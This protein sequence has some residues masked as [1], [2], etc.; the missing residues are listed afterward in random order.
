M[1]N[2]SR[3]PLVAHRVFPAANAPDLHADERA[4][5]GL[6]RDQLFRRQ[7]ARLQQGAVQLAR[8]LLHHKGAI[9]SIQQ[10]RADTN[11][12]FASNRLSLVLS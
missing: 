2:S 11:C 10:P 3:P 1:S 6:G 7:L 9:N 8:V 5:L 12:T 4:Q